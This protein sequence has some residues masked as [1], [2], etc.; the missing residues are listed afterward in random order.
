M[1]ILKRLSIKNLKMNKKRSISTIVGIIL[2]TALICGTATLVS[3]FQRTLIQNAINETGYYHLKIESVDENQIGD[4]KKEKSVKRNFWDWKCW[5]WSFKTVLRIKQNHMWSYSQWIKILL[6]CLILNW[7]HGR[8]PENNNEII[9]S[10]HI[11]TN[12]KV[13]LKLGDNI[14]FDIG[15]R[16]TLD[17]EDLNASNPYIEAEEKIT[18]SKQYNFTVVRDYRK[19]W[20]WI[21]R[22]WRCW[23]FCYNYRST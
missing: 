9:I 1:N 5:I 18:D 4:I 13:D 21:W 20:I 12:G 19:T 17:G 2:S 16:Q 3:S 15:K 10:R 23:I 11:L 6:I 8:F 7:I 22:T 14:S